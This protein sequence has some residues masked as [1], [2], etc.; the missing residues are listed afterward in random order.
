MSAPRYPLD[1]TS[2]VH[3]GSMLA[4]IWTTNWI[5]RRSKEII[6]EPSAR[7]SARN[8]PDQNKPTLQCY[9]KTDTITLYSLRSGSHSPPVHFASSMR[10][11]LLS[12][13]FWSFPGISS[14]PFPPTPASPSFVAS[15][16]LFSFIHLR[17][18][19]L[20]LRSLLTE[21]TKLRT[22][23]G[24]QTQRLRRR[25]RVILLQPLLLYERA[26]R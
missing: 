4:M 16:S 23:T 5:N 7:A 15:S 18:V 26:K 22:D 1:R 19:P 24:A 21:S 6:I 25:P 13:S 8:S 10:Q 20:S 17:P 12:Q 9:I 14:T 2:N 3:D 11:S